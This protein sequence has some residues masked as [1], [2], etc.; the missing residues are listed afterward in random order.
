MR[1]ASC[2]VR[3]A[4]PGNSAG[5][6]GLRR[7]ALRR[8]KALALVALLV[9]AKP[10]PAAL[11]T[12]SVGATL[13]PIERTLPNGLRV[14]VFEVH[15]LP[16][17]QIELVVPA[18]QTAEPPDEAGIALLVASMLARGTASRDAATFDADAARLG[19][20][21]T[22]RASRDVM[23]MA[24][25]FLSAHLAAGMELMSD[26]AVN[27]LFD[28]DKIQARR[29]LHLRTL[30]QLRRDPVSLADQEIWAAVFGDR[31]YGRA[32]LG[33]DSSIVSLTR[34]A[35][36]RFHRDH[37]RPDR[38]ILV[39]A[40]DVSADS[41]FAEAATWFGH[42]EGHAR[43]VAGSRAPAR[44]ARP[45]VRI[46]DLPNAPYTSV[47][48]GAV[49]PGRG[50]SDE[51]PL[52]VALARF[53]GGA[54]SWLQR[55]PVRRRLGGSVAGSL[56][57][58]TDGG[59]YTFGATVTT[60]SAGATV[61]LLRDQLE[62][63][64]RHS[65]T[66]AEI[67][68]LRRAASFG[69][70][71]PLE[72]LGGLIG[73]WSSA[74]SSGLPGDALPRAAERLAGVSAREIAEACARWLNPDSLIIVAVGPAR[75]LEP[76][77]AAFGRIEVVKVPLPPVP[78]S[79]S[80]AVTPETVA[81]GRAILE[82]ALRAHGGVDSML[83]I[84]DSVIDMKVSLGPPPG[85]M[86]GTLTQIRKEPG[87]MESVTHLQGVDVRE[88]LNG[89]QAWSMMSSTQ[90]AQDADSTEVAALRAGFGSDL[91][92]LLL[93]LRADGVR[94]AGGPATRIEQ[95]EVE[96]VEMR[97]ARGEWS[98]YYFDAHTHLLSAIDLFQDAPG[99]GVAVARRL[100][101]GYRTVGGL[102]WPFREVRLLNG[103]N[104][105]RF[106]VQSV[107]LNFGITDREFDRPGRMR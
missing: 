47:R 103:E 17:V 1:R 15:R 58:L 39:V 92:H 107:K 30:R 24:G 18:G 94:L 99:E 96:C 95:Q 56:L 50:A 57:E 54:S 98:K 14:A 71:A 52:S 81:L 6:H 25:G 12:G 48:L 22:V 53:S 20:T 64:L 55:P 75:S 4:G 41:A 102:Q 19:G 61:R 35:A 105:R 21:I 16:I 42:W 38:T 59:L 87:K 89:E 49:L 70:L 67:A 68:Q 8:F 27:P 97:S 23:S 74:A 44:A 46:V 79:D 3:A 66:D 28:D 90:S 69:F 5:S 78:R 7:V 101:S 82:R 93:A 45:R 106:E 88:V 26:A 63:F 60:D 33:T 76:Q 65:P 91:P 10:A 9:P 34:G 51:L 83:A 40:G 100:Y 43:P 11:A 62:E 84:H 77:L 86:W 80:V 32:P 31:P 37:F 13:V 85:T 29:S 104:L 72:T 2:R 36:E 73:E